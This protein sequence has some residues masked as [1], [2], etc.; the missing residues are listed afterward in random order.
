MI[1]KQLLIPSCAALVALAAAPQAAHA[2]TFQFVTLQIP[3]QLGSNASDINDS[4][5]VVGGYTDSRRRGHGLVWVNGTYT[6]VDVPGAKDTQLVWVNNAGLA[7]GVATIPHQDDIIFTY[8]IATGQQ[9]LIGPKK[10]TNYAVSGISDDGEVFGGYRHRQ[11][12][13]TYIEHDGKLK[14]VTLPG[15]ASFGINTITDAGEWLGLYTTTT[16]PNTNHGFTYQGKTLTSFDPPGSVNTY[17]FR[18]APDG[19]IEG[20]FHTAQGPETGFYL[21]N[22]TYTTYFYPGAFATVMLG[23]L[24]ATYVVG[25]YTNSSATPSAFIFNAGTYTEY[26]PNGSVGANLGPINA[27]G[28]VVGDYVDGSNEAFGQVG[29]CPAGQAPC[30]P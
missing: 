22:G 1:F 16:D 21:A 15:A 30:M 13:G 5:Q 28:S 9:T 3:N 18:F 8:D 10:R 26:T 23:A 11:K 14:P 2:G 25:Y 17:P 24:N 7:A 4:N 6:T 27:S 20:D 12:Y 29:I 19:G